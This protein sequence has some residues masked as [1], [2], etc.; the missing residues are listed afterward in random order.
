MSDKATLLEFGFSA[1]R[2]EKALKATNNSGLQPALDWLDAH[3]NDAGI[4]DPAVNEEPTAN[5]EEATATNEHAQS[6]KCNECNKL[7]SSADLAQVHAT[8]TGHQDFAESTEAIKP[9]TEEEKKQKLDEIQRR[10]AEKRQ[11]REEAEKEEQRQNELLRR[12]AGQDMTEQ[13]EK[14]KD[15]MLLR[16]I[17][18]QKREKED[19]KRAKQ[20]IKDQIEQDKRDRAVRVAK[21]KAERDGTSAPAT[22]QAEEPGAPSMLL[23]GLPKVTSDSN[24]TRLQIRPMLQSNKGGPAPPVTH[25]FA[26]DQTL[27]DVINF[28][29]KEMPHVGSHFKLSMSFPRKDFESHHESMTLKDLGLVPNAA[30]ILTT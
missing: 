12:K 1:V 3:A 30:L 15:Q 13:K 19:D 25:I 16:E 5:T 9:L 6:I 20:K 24:Q 28:V 21:E 2:I 17:E 26:A 4:D 18:K 14:L 27:K 7:F 11:K 29:K 23:S 22:A 10:I 8:K